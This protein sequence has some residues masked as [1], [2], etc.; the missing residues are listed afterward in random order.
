[1]LEREECKTF[2]LLIGNERSVNLSSGSQLAG[3]TGS[4]GNL[5]L[6]FAPYLNM[7]LTR[8][9]AAP[10]CLNVGLYT[11]SSETLY[12]TRDH[13]TKVLVPIYWRF[14]ERT[15]GYKNIYIPGCILGVYIS[16]YIP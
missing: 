7:P 5:P 1:M 8:Y 12:I 16:P 9:Y 13:G 15:K 11:V 2:K 4:T 6:T 3:S 10:I 14:D